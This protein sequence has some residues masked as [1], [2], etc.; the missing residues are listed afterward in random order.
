MKDLQKKKVALDVTVFEYT[1][2]VTKRG[3]KKHLQQGFP[4]GSFRDADTQT[5]LCAFA[6]QKE[7]RSS[8]KSYVYFYSWN[9]YQYFVPV[10]VCFYNGNL[11]GVK[12]LITN[13]RNMVYNRTKPV[14]ESKN[15]LDSGTERV[16]SF[17]DQKLH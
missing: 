8:T 9:M 2:A 17:S 15:F 13:D 6:L 12:D 11:K 3:K 14:I 7:V 10:T 1:S 16:I 5:V 4:R